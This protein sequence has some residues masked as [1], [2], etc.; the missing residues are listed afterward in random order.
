MIESL[1]IC[2]VL[3]F[4]ICFAAGVVLTLR[5]EDQ[6]EIKFKHFNILIGVMTWTIF[7]IGIVGI[8]ALF[9][10]LIACFY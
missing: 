4:A 10:K 5:Y 3:F 9:H 7:A 2:F 1:L 8:L 6:V